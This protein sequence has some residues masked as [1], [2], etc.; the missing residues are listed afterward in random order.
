MTKQTSDEHKYSPYQI[1]LERAISEVQDMFLITRFNKKK[2]LGLGDVR[3][4]IGDEE[5]LIANIR[6]L[7]DR[8][9]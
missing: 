7:K 8:N 5:N 9:F 4:T 3:L 2:H 6:S 1:G